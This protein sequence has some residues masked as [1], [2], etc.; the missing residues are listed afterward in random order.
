MFLKQCVILQLKTNLQQ[1][2]TKFTVYLHEVI[3]YRSSLNII[4]IYIYTAEVT[5]L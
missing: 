3:E 2:S 4:K 5:G 1:V